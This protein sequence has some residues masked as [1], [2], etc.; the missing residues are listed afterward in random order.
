MMS[1]QIQ[2]TVDGTPRTVASDSKPTLIFEEIYPDRV[3][4]GANCI[5]VCK[6][7]GVLRDLWT[8]LTE[9]DVIESIAINSEEGLMV[10]RHSTA[11]VLAQAV[12]ETFPQT[13]LGI[14]PPIKDG[15]YY[16]FDPEKPFTPE[17]LTRL[18]SVMKKII[19][20]GQRFKRRP[21][22]DS[23]A[24]KELT[25]EPYKCELVTLKSS[26]AAEGASVEVGAGEL[27][28]YDNLG[29]D[30]KA[31]WGDLCRGPHIPSTKYIPAYKLMRSAGAYWR[32]SEKNPML[33]RIYGTAW[34]SQ[35]ELDQYLHLLAEAEKRDHRRLGAELD[36]FSFPEEIGSGL[37]VFHPKGGI[38]RR[39][40][41][42]YSRK[43]HEEEDYQFVYSPHLTKAALFETSGHLQWYAEGMYP[44]MVMDEEL[45]ADGTIKKAGQKYYMKPMNC[46]F[47]NLIFQS[48]PKSYRDLPLRLFEFGTVY[49]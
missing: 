12:Q 44:P 2:V 34:P 46:P 4:P 40:M 25:H 23:D 33:Q 31:V 20:D 15:F 24:L 16:D 27:T 26:D 42:D 28:I 45:H 8:D 21:I 7:N 32:G 35:E 19:K 29:R 9:G 22:T 11:H 30:G 5:V 13:R 14:G 48:T 39:A 41:E 3:K 10:L 47:H 17:D 18:E 43:R 6:I 1:A 37:A 38:V 49:R 36:L